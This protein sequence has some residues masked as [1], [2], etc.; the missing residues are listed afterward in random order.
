MAGGF[1]SL[2]FGGPAAEQGG[3]GEAREQRAPTARRGGP[4]PERYGEKCGSRNSVPGGRPRAAPAAFIPAPGGPCSRWHRGQHH[5]HFP[6][7]RRVKRGNVRADPHGHAVGFPRR[8]VAV[9]HR[10]RPGHPQRPVRHAGHAARRAPRERPPAGVGPPERPS[11]AAAAPWRP[12][13]AGRLRGHA[14]RHHGRPPGPDDHAGP[15]PRLHDRA[16][17]RLRLQPA[18]QDLPDRDGQWIVED[19]GSTNG[20][21]LDRSRLTS[22]TP[23]PLGAPIRI[24]KTVIELRK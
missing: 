4:R 14:H 1:T 7:S 8:T 12:H 2:C 19:L 23:V 11:A 17:R 13:E 5:H 21:Y 3:R 22:P 24:G 6:A 16:G 20:T 15:G 9:R 10:G 18:C